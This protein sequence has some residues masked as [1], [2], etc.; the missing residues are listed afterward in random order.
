MILNYNIALE[1][2][3]FRRILNYN[4]IGGLGIFFL[5]VILWSPLMPWT[6]LAIP[7]WIILIISLQLLLNGVLLMNYYSWMYINRFISYSKQQ[8][9]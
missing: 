3:N 7:A 9:G 6:V 5:V 4:I 2:D 1:D 8:Y